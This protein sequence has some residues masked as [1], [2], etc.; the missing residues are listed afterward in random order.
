MYT[1]EEKETT[2]SDYK[3]DPISIKKTFLPWGLYILLLLLLLLLYL[4]TKQIS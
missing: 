2:L 4:Y 1:K 3:G